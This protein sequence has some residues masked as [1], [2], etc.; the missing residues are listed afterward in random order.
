MESAYDPYAFVH[1]VWLQ[2]REYQVRDGDVPAD[3]EPQD[4]TEK[5]VPRP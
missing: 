5:A 3:A 2:R 1:N 4:D